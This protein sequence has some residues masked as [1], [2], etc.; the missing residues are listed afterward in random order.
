MLTTEGTE[1]RRKL[2]EGGREE[3]EAFSNVSVP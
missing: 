2:Y 1:A 3:R